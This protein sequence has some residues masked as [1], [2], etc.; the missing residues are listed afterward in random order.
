MHVPLFHVLFGAGLNATPAVIQID[1]ID[2]RPPVYDTINCDGTEGSISECN[3][4][5]RLP[6]CAFGTVGVTCPVPETGKS[7]AYIAFSISLC[8]KNIIYHLCMDG[9]LIHST[10]LLGGQCAAAKWI[11]L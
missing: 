4:R 8:P 7:P 9:Y 1:G 3:P 6:F 2:S 11:S 5:L 10:R